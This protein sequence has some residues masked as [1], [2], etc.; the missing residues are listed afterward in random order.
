MLFIIFVS[1]IFV[2]AVRRCGSPDDEYDIDR[3]ELISVVDRIYY[4]KNQF[5]SIDELI[6]EIETSDSHY[7]KNLRVSWNSIVGNSMDA[8]FWCDGSSE[9]TKSMLETAYKRRDETY[10]SLLREVQKIL[11]VAEKTKK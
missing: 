4:L 9:V 2:M 7:V 3:E 6:T 10:T 5:V 1:V 11:D 8:D